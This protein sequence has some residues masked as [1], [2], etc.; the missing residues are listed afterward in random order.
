[1]IDPAV[2]HSVFSQ[3]YI[4]TRIGAFLAGGGLVRVLVYISA[5]MPPLPANSGFWATW[6]YAVMK[7]ASGLD[8]SATVI[9]PKGP[10]EH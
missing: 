6:I 2:S 3:H 8:P 1:M 4:S 5:Q 10:N 7:G 9:P